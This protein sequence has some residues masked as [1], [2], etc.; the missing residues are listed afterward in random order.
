MEWEGI[1]SKID[2][3]SRTFD[4]CVPSTTINI[5]MS[6]TSGK[7]ASSADLNLTLQGYEFDHGSIRKL[8]KL[9]NIRVAQ[10]DC[11]YRVAMEGPTSTLSNFRNL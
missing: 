6:L 4:D 3:G 5:G 1:R 9:L 11:H 2:Y 10:R 8:V 7:N